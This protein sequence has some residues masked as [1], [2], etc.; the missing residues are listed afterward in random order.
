[1]QRLLIIVLFITSSLSLAQ[2][3]HRNEFSIKIDNDA[4][5][6]TDKYYSNGLEF[7]YQRRI[8]S[9]SS[10]TRIRFGLA[11]KIYTPEATLS[12]AI[13][14]GDHPYTGLYYGTLGFSHVNNSFYLKA[15]L[16]IGKQGPDAKAGI[17]QNIFHKMTP[18]SQVNGWENQTANSSFYNGDIKFIKIYRG[19]FLELSPWLEVRYGGLIQD[20]ELG[21]KFGLR[22]GFFELFSNASVVSSFYNSILQGPKNAESVYV[23]AP[24]NMKDIYYKADAGMHFVFSGFRLSLK[25][26]WYSAQFD[27]AHS[28]TYGTLETAFFF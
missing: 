20:V 13:V 6:E 16:W 22:A 7:M 9:D 24:E 12:T 14:E 25:A 23:I 19:S 28:H 3:R 5:F 21:L 26:N 10:L 2:D 4:A 11:H 18:S 17:F 8:A 1:M 15:D 27:G